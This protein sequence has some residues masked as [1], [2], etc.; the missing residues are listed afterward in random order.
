MKH[1]LVCFKADRKLY[2]RTSVLTDV[3]VPVEDIISP[4]KTTF[5]VPKNDKI[6]LSDYV[7][8]QDNDSGKVEYIGYIDTLSNKQTTEMTC[9]PIINIFDNDFLLDQMFQTVKKGS[10]DANGQWKEN[11]FETE[12][13]DVD[14]DAVDWLYKQIRRAFVETEDDFQAFPFGVLKSTKVPIYY[15]KAIDTANL[16]EAYIDLFINTGIYVDF[17]GL[18]FNRNEITSI[19]CE[20]KCNKEERQYRIYEHDPSLQKVD[21]VDNTFKNYNKIIA[22]EEIAVDENGNPISD[23]DPQVYSFYLLDNNDISMEHDDKVREDKEK[24]MEAEQGLQ[25]GS[26]KGTLGRRIQQVRTK[27]I[28]FNLASGEAEETELKKALLKE[29]GYT[30][31]QITAFLENPNTIPQTVANNINVAIQ[32]SRAKSLILSIYNELQAPEY[33]LKIEIEMLKNENLHLYRNIDFVSNKVVNGKNIVYNSNITKIEKLNDKQVRITL[34]ALRNS[35]TDFK[36]KV[37][38]I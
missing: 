16:F 17:T 12:T 25:S 26:L 14:V 32:E 20:I 9:Y 29:E 8:L 10:Y 28:S 13:E 27:V 4:Q 1:L 2:V 24:Q 21:I 5:V 3:S 37:E 6:Q 23:K 15:K 33:D 18:K 31:E 30:D 36:K 7:I 35:L 11:L 22:V 34:G 19:I 38:A